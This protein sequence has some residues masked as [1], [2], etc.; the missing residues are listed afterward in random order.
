MTVK[1]VKSSGRTPGP[2]RV[3]ISADM[4]NIGVQPQKPNIGQ[5]AELLRNGKVAGAQRFPALGAG[6][7]YPLQ[8]RLFR[9]PATRKDPLQVLVRYVLD[10]RKTA[11]M[12]N[13]SAVNDSLQKIF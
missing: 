11:N 7:T 13:C 4:S 12:E 9:D 5:H 1:I 10:D 3:L 8:F 2:D 6:I